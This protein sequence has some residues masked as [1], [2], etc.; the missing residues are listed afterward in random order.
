MGSHFCSS[1]MDAKG[2]LEVGTCGLNDSADLKCHTLL[3]WPAHSIS[4]TSNMQ[5]ARRSSRLLKLKNVESDPPCVSATAPMNTSII[6]SGSCPS[7]RKRLRRR[8]SAG[9]TA[10]PPVEP[11]V[12]SLSDEDSSDDNP[13]EAP[14]AADTPENYSKEQRYEE[15]RNVYQTKAQF[16]QELMRPKR[17]SMT[18]KFF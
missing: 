2:I 11:E 7:S 9:D 5:P 16:Y 12:E 14:A 10:P 13:D 3:S 8:V 18:G 15:S 17:M 4:L 6:P 1:L